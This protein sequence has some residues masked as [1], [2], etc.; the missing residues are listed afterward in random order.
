[1]KTSIKISLLLIFTVALFVRARYTDHAKDVTLRQQA[2]IT[3]PADVKAVIDNK[4]YGCHSKDGRSE[5]AKEHM[6]WDSIPL[7]PQDRQIEV[8]DDIAEVLE[9]GK[10]PPEKMIEM[11]PEAKLSPDQVTLIKNWAET[12]ADELMK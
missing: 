6:M 3:F 1:M 8:L 4:C 9:K 7:Y 5:E 12:T 11:H 2:E 10:M